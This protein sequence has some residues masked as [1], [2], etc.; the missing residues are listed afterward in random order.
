MGVMDKLLHMG[1]GRQ[2]KRLENIARQVNLVE[3]DFEAM[4]D[5]ELRGMTDEFRRRLDEYIDFLVSWPRP[6]VGKKTLMDLVTRPGT[7]LWLIAAVGTPLIVSG[8]MD[9]VWVR[10]TRPCCSAPARAASRPR[11]TGQS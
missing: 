7:F 10:A 3:P 11:S 2:I 1:E 5:E 4:S 9:P 8:R 6:F